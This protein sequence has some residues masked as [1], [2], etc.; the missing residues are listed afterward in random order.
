[1]GAAR[2]TEALVWKQGWAGLSSG[3]M[4]LRAVQHLQR[5]FRAEPQFELWL[6]RL[7]SYGLLAAAFRPDEPVCVLRS[8]LR[9][10]AML[11]TYAGQHTQ[12]MQKAL[13]Q[14]NVKLQHVLS[15]ITG[16]TG[17]AIIRAIVAGQRDPVALAKL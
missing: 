16:V 6:Q 9:Q 7:H 17:L 4:L 2:L 3:L 5:Q 13:T 11:V 15:D 10:R 8:Y 14:M 12:H 1:R